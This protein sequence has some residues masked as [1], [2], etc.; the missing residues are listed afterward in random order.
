MILPKKR[1]VGS[2]GVGCLKRRQKKKTKI[3]LACTP[4]K[5]SFELEVGK[6][7]SYLVTFSCPT[8]HPGYAV[9]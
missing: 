3:F 2:G 8:Y 5:K 7:D 1:M 9:Y 4:Q 6:R